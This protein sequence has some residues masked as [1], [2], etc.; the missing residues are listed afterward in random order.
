MIASRLLVGALALGLALELAAPSRASAWSCVNISCPRW[1]EAPTYELGPP[2][3]DL[4]AIAPGT[5]YS[6]ARDGLLDWTIVGCGGFVP[7]ETAT[8]AP[9]PVFG[10]RT[11]TIGWYDTGWPHDPN[12]IG[13]TTS[14]T[15]SGCLVEA[16]IEF[17]G[18]N[19]AW[20]T[21]PG[22]TGVV[23]A[24]SAMVHE[25]GHFYG[26][27]HSEYAN[28][29]MYF[30][31][32]RGT[33]QITPDDTNGYC[34]LYPPSGPPL[35]CTTLG[36]PRGQVC[37]AGACVTAP[38]PPCTTDANCAATDR[39]DLAS[40]KCV[41]RNPGMGLGV[42]CT[43]DAECT[44]GF[45]AE[46]ASGS[47]CSQTC[48][49]LN[50]RSCPSGFYCSGSAVNDCAVGICLPGTSG[51]GGYGSA[52]ASDVECASL[53]C[54]EGHCSTPCDPSGSTSCPTGYVCH[55]M[56]RGACGACGRPRGNGEPCDDDSQCMGGV[57]FAPTV[58]AAGYCTQSCAEGTA[59]PAGYRCDSSGATPVCTKV[60]PTSDGCDCAAAPG[61]GGRRGLPGLGLLLG[62]VLFFRRRRSR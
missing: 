45:C 39:C 59:C 46:T 10:D 61:S 50:T 51:S 26:L 4:E 41:T 5:S 27:G 21:S 31:Y 33:R 49:A 37:D 35:D 55:P 34:S 9:A 42:A 17:N 43:S 18:V 11:N 25:S 52:C 19:Y 38:T 15:V 20:T 62:A 7:T 8:N 29:A 40:G 12:V 1:C 6:E 2:S 56:A 13:M 16:D 22:S 48:N 54:A 60:P 24:Y 57:C 28:A 53:Y 23:N 36:C 14:Q 3:A 47:I 32:S 44:T 58:E 30:S